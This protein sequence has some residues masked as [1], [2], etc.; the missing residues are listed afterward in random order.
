M[1]SPGRR[2]GLDVADDFCPHGKLV[3]L[4]G[5]QLAQH[6]RAEPDL[7]AFSRHQRKC[8]PADGA[9]SLNL[10]ER[11]GGEAKRGTLFRDGR[12]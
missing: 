10:C 8:L 1:V 4:E 9:C 6:V 5:V 11:L 7:H 3:G 12:E 2:D